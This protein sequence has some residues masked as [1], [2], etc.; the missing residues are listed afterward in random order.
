MRFN[1]RQGAAALLAGVLALSGCSSDDTASTS[2][3]EATTTAAASAAASY[4]VTVTNCGRELTFDAAPKRVL[5]LNGT[6]VGEVETFITLGLESSIVANAQSYGVSDDPDMVAKVAE[7]PTGGIT[8]DQS[9][10]EVPKEQ[11]VNLRPDLVVSTWAG[12]FSKT[13][14]TL[15]RDELDDLGIASYVTPSNCAY[16][17]DAAS[18]ADKAAYA[19]QSYE[20]SYD[21]VRDLGTIFGVEDR[22]AEFIADS[23][24]RIA[25]A[26]V[27][28]TGDAP[29]VLLAFPGM[30]MM[31]SSGL[32]A[33][34]G[35]SLYD[36]II[37]AAGGENSFKGRQFMEM[38]TINAEDL[39]AADVDVLAVGL[40]QPT[41][42]AKE[43]AEALFAQY[44]QWSA[45]KNKAYVGVADGVYLGPN[46]A[47]AIEKLAKAI[48]DAR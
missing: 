27:E 43:M 36:S 34:F 11:I 17:D 42:D 7:L 21:L 6:S 12:G 13:A 38:S 29:K 24:K 14:G 25:E 18:D 20:S 8:L 46:N 32:P 22:A 47:I 16:G 31:N 9:T 15:T 4:P 19:A 35:G 5:I 45:S 37:A 10:Y 44:P 3:D 26:K 2:G 39:A 1:V 40:F 28:A 33:V 30:S 41:D 23:E 48:A